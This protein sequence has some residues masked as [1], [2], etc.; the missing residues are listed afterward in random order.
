VGIAC[1]PGKFATEPEKAVIVPMVCGI[2]AQG[3]TAGGRDSNSEQDEG[4]ALRRNLEDRL[5]IGAK[6]RIY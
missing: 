2:P 1:P 6:I 4:H 5:E 3:I